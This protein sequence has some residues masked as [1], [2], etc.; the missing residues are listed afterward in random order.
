MATRKGLGWQKYAD[1][2][3]V[4]TVRFALVDKMPWDTACPQYLS[5]RAHK[6]PTKCEL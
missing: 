1:R 3:C 4:V 2:R 5:V 6:S